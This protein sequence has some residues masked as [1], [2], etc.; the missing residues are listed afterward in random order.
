VAIDAS[1]GTLARWAGVKQYLPE[2]DGARLDDIVDYQT[3]VLVPIVLMIE[4]GLLAGP[5][6]YTAATAA[7][8]ASAYRFC[9]AGAKTADHFFTGFPSYWNI[10]ALYLYL[11]GM[12]ATVSGLVTLVLAGLVF[13]PLRFIYPSRMVWLRTWTVGLGALW[14]V[15]VVW[16]VLTLDAPPRGLTSASLLYPIYYNCLS[17][18][19]QWRGATRPAT[20]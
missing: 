7:L 18:Y 3:Y 6:G 4:T 5:L 15:S 1:D 14:A 9:Q 12:P 13:S 16:L 8:L 11:Y 20:R 17:F 19:L 10:V 2:F